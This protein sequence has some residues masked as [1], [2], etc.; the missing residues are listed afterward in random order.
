MLGWTCAGHSRTKKKRAPIHF[1]LHFFDFQNFQM[2][3][4]NDEDQACLTSCM[5]EI[6]NVVG[7]SVSERQLV[8]TIMKFKFDFAKSLDAILNNTTT[9]PSAK[10]VGPKPSTASLNKE[11]V[12]TGDIF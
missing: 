12:E 9:P 3:I 11:P 6:R 10:V 8:D 4:L 7:E 5:D 2:P 1:H